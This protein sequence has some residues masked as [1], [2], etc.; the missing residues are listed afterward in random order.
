[1]FGRYL[2]S[3]PY[4]TYGGILA[5][6]PEAVLALVE[7]AGELARAQGVKHVELRHTAKLEGM[8]LPE[9]LD[10]VSMWLALPDSNEELDKRLGSKLRSQIRRA[11]RENPE[12]VFGGPELIGEFYE[13]F[14]ATMHALGTPVYSRRFFDLAL[15]AF[16]D[17]ARVIVVR[18]AGKVAAAAIT[19]RHGNRLETPWAAATPPAKRAAINMRLYRETLTEAIRQ[20]L[21]FF[22]FGRSSQDSGTLRFKA[23]WGAEPVQLHWNYWLAAG[24]ELPV[25]NHSNPKYARAAAVW[26]RM[27][28]W[29]ANAIGPVIAKN[30]P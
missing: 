28:L 21:D 3:L 12:V 14:A 15:D 29:C 2:V 24:A 30:L 19:V 18:V 26:R 23:Q 25:L 17:R 20:S 8:A 4:F 10:K 9:R 13:V 22:D 27:P 1:V 5:D 16:G 6:A 7:S 11:E